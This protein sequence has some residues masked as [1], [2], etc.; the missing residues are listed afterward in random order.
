MCFG[1]YDWKTFVP[2]FTPLIV[3]AAQLQLFRIK[4]FELRQVCWSFEMWR[5]VNTC[6]A[7]V[8]KKTDLLYRF[9]VTWLEGHVTPF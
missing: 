4:T 3:L 7:C 8:L 2:I 1:T 9:P 5:K 6:K